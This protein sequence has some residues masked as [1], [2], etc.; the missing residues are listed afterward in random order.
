MHAHHAIFF[1]DEIAHG[2]AALELEAGEFRGLGDNH[3]EHRGLR[4]NARRRIEAVDLNCDHSPFAAEN[5]DR[6][7]R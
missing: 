1:V 4:R 2:Y 3:L 5:L 6:S 7:K